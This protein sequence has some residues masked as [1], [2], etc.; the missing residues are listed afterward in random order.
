MIDKKT[1][2]NIKL[3]SKFISTLIQYQGAF[4]KLKEIG[5]Y[6]PHTLNARDVT[7]EHKY[8]YSICLAKALFILNE[9]SYRYRACFILTIIAISA[10]PVQWKQ[11]LYSTHSF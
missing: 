1:S 7:I 11:S 9:L 3:I 5:L 4:A 8:P 10:G 2:V 6:I